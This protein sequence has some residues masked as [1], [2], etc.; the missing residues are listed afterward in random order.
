MTAITA[1]SWQR[2]DHM[3]H[4]VL[5]FIDHLLASLLHPPSRF[6]ICNASFD[7]ASL[8]LGQLRCIGVPIVCDGSTH[9]LLRL[10]PVLQISKNAISMCT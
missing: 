9:L 7:F 4:L 3:M 2:L 6:P 5:K 1:A 8:S 10:D